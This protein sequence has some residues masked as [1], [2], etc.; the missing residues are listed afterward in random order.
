MPSKEQQQA[1]PLS[2]QLARMAT[3]VV[4]LTVAFLGGLCVDYYWRTHFTDSTVPALSTWISR[5]VPVTLMLLLLIGLIV[6][7]ASGFYS[8]GRSYRGRYKALIITEATLFTFLGYGA[9]AYGLKSVID[10]PPA[11]AIAS[12]AVIALVELLV[13]RLYSSVWKNLLSHPVE[14]SDWQTRAHKNS[15]ET[16]RVLV[17]GGAGYIGSALVPQL[18]DAGYKV[19]VL[20][21]FMFG[22]EPIRPYLSHPDL[23]AREADFR[24][25][26]QLVENMAD[27]HTVVHLGGIVGDPACAVDEEFTIEV[28]LAATRAIAEVAKAHGIRRFIFASTCSVY[29]ASD[30]IMDERSRL[31]PVSLYAKSKIASERVL[32]DLSDNNFRPT[33]LRFGTV[34]GLSGRTRFDLVVN[35]LSAK[36][37]HD[38]QITVFGPDQWRPFVHVSDVAQAVLR[39]VQAPQDVVAGRIFNVGS[40][41]QNTTLGALGRLIGSK[42]PTAELVISEGDGDRRNYRV[43]FDRIQR[44]LQFEPAW[45][46]EA[47]IEQVLQAVRSG[48]V[49]DYNGQSYSNLKVLQDLV[50]RK[51]VTTQR[52]RHIELLTSD[53]GYVESTGTTGPVTTAPAAEWVSEDSEMR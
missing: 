19:R 27:V 38:G 34:Y 42:V 47:G 18:L 12:A 52:R 37:V 30:E 23:E 49:V 1:R 4:I 14:A 2:A 39:A 9:I 7:T 26:D 40:N 36:A 46:L 17:I 21:A 48:A 43:N 24:R 33:I 3:D 29:G 11:L 41:G 35:L 32:A 50:Q 53:T 51:A 31:N 16:N 22:D 45:T 10:F 15:R 25:I 13:A 5:F 28:N 6:F 44:E 8:R 20:D